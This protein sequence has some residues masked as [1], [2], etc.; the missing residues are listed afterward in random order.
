MRTQTQREDQVETQG[1]DIHL[2]AKDQGLR[3]NQSY[4]HLAFGHQ[5]SRIVKNKVSL[6]K[7]PDM[8]YFAMA[9]LA[10]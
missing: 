10:N 4:Q 6:V 2:Q 7:L 9:T 5:A 1:E 8:W 3:R